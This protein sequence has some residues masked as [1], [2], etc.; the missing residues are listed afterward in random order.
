MTVEAIGIAMRA[1]IV[2]ARAHIPMFGEEALIVRL[3]TP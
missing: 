2:V 1:T 3:A